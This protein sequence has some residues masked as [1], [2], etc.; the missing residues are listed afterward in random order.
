[1]IHARM[2]GVGM[3]ALV[4]AS[5]PGDATHSANERDS[6]VAVADTIGLGSC[7][8]L[9]RHARAPKG[10]PEPGDTVPPPN[11]GSWTD[12]KRVAL[13]SFSI[14]VPRVAAVRHRN[15]RD[16]YLITNLPTCRWNRPQNSM[17]ER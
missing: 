3:I 4:L 11:P 10:M 15:A 6:F 14:E 2:V 7:A 5:S 17:P 16:S 13:D 9:D 8:S 12:I 1:M